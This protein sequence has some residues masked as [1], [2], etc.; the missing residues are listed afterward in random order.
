MKVT[1]I[2]VTL[3]VGLINIGLKELNILFEKA[4]VPTPLLVLLKLL[5]E[6]SK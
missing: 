2:T 1:I 4:L 6:Q 5:I 3:K